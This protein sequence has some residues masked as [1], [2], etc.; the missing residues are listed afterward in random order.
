[1]L[2]LSVTNKFVKIMPCIVSYY[3]EFGKLNNTKKNKY[4]QFC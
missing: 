4:S 1:M 3:D 2:N